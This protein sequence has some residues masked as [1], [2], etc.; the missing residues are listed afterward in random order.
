MHMP[1]TLLIQCLNTWNWIFPITF[2]A[3]LPDSGCMFTLFKLNRLFGP[4]VL[5]QSEIPVILMT[6]KMKNMCCS[7]F[8]KI[9]HPGIKTGAYLPSDPRAKR[10][11][12]WMDR[13][14]EDPFILETPITKAENTTHRKREWLHDSILDTCSFQECL[15]LLTN[16]ESPGPDGT[17]NELFKHLPQEYNESIHKLFVIMWA[18]GITPNAWKK[19][20]TILIYKDK[21]SQ[22][23]IASYQPIG[24]ANTIYKLRTCLV[25]TAMYEYAEIHSLLS[26]M[27]TGLRKH[28]NTIHQLQNLIMALEDSKI[29]NRDIYAMIVD[30]TSAFNTTDHDKLPWITNT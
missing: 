24:L 20:D 4:V 15:R 18:T 21:G 22:A 19:C 25:T 13:Q 2:F 5:L 11:Y 29:F 3:T 7:D 8:F 14:C 6:Y 27:K 9:P 10:N 16:K 26:N 12:P 17:A 30:F 28:M 1:S 23:D